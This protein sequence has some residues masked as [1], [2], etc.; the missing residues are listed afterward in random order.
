MLHTFSV[1]T[2]VRLC[3]FFIKSDLHGT[4]C[5]VRFVVYS[6]LCSKNLILPELLAKDSKIG[7]NR[8]RL[9]LERATCP[10]YTTNRTRQ[11]VPGCQT[12][13]PIE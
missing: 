10:S 4:I 1:Y 7:F 11:I 8:T 3:L 6:S 12:E 2:I 13:G 5:R 9:V